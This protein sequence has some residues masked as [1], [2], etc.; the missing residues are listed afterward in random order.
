MLRKNTLLLLALLFLA[1]FTLAQ[2][3]T[4]DSTAVRALV[5][6]DVLLRKNNFSNFSL[7][8]D[9]KFFAE[10]MSVNGREE[11]I[12]IDV[13]AYTMLH[14]IDMDYKEIDALY[15]LG[16]KRL[17]Y[18]SGG[19]IYS[20]D[21]DGNNDQQI[22]GRFADIM[23]KGRYV[24]FYDNLRYNSVI[25]LMPGNDHQILIETHDTDLN[26][27]VKRVNLFTGQKY[28]VINGSKHKINQ[29]ITDITGEVRLGMRYEDDRI[30]YQIFDAATEEWVPFKIKM[31]GGIY[32]LEIAGDTF[33][34]Q[35]LTFEGFGIRKDVIYL[36]T[37]IGKD[38]RELIA[39]DIVK[40]E[41]LETLV[42]DVNVDV[43]DPN[44]Q[45]LNFI[46]DPKE[47][48]IA[49][50]QYQGVVP[51][52]KLFTER[53]KTIEAQLKAKYPTMVHEFFDYDSNGNRFVIYQY[54]DTY[55]GNIGIYDVAKDEYAVMLQ[56]NE[57]LNEFKL[58]KTKPLIV[59]SRDGA[60]IPCYV[61]LPVDYDPNA[62]TPM[63]VIPHGGPWSRD[64]WGLDP[65]ST[66]FAD[67]GFITLRVNFRGSTGF[68]KE[69]TMAGV[70]SLDKV[71]IDD[72]VDAAKTVQLQ[73]NIAPENSFIFGHSYGGYATYMA[74]AKYKELFKSG[75]AVSAPTDIRRWMKE[76]K[77]SG[78]TFNYKFWQMALGDKNSRYMEE[79]SPLTYADQIGT[80]LLIFHG[81]KDRT[82]PV[83]HAED[84]EK[85]LKKAGKKVHLEIMKSEGHNLD[86]SNV[87]GYLLEQS[88]SFFMG[89]Y[90]AEQ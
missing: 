70:S 61:N 64:D 38:K 49:G 13:D 28:N 2:E 51:V 10:V 12:I 11:I 74:L 6:T 80:E 63:V 29:W 68:G 41:V 73:Y 25:S 59:K 81:A 85:A 30:T 7:S 65:F 71:M 34:N 90:Q 60:N 16:N 66:Y 55:A 44:G 50:V 87:L 57:E 45:P 77:K 88:R 72:I 24:S 58:A 36:T 37:N 82:I 75:V 1:P 26:A 17:I 18:E 79:I 9:G 39:Y 40:G 14:R 48:R 22:V 21:T 76:Q 53:F 32:P 67:R 20:I 31:D 23:K 62:N 27:I 54:S 56:M 84:M 83:D 3:T 42:S 89:E 33:L 46:F 4:N 69:H 8:P 19:G 47:G 5:P 43:Y 15:W 86:N 35:N 52:T 78:N